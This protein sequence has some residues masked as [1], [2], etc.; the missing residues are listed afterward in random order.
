MLW[1]CLLSQYILNWYKNVRWWW[2]SAETDISR[3]RHTED[4]EMMM[5]Q[6]KLVKS[7][8]IKTLWHLPVVNT[9]NWFYQADSSVLWELNPDR[10]DRLVTSCEGGYSSLL[11][12]IR[13][14]TATTQSLSLCWIIL[15]SAND[16]VWWRGLLCQLANHTALQILASIFLYHDLTRNKTHSG[17][18][19]PRIK[20]SKPTSNSIWHPGTPEQC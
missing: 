12:Y 4:V 15:A 20:R 1:T 7:P 19:S 10:K 14:I 16:S 11:S 9:G 13:P 8:I 3:G 5:Y 17:R 6:Y 18:T 2:W